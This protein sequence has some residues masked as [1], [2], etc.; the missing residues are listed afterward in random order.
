MNKLLS[1]TQL[2]SNF[3]EGIPTSE[4]YQGK[5]HLLT[6]TDNSL[7]LVNILIRKLNQALFPAYDFEKA[8]KILASD[9]IR[10]RFHN[11]RQS[12]YRDQRVLN[13]FAQVINELTEQLSW[14]FKPYV[15][16]P[17]F[18]AILP[19]MHKIPEAAD[20]FSAHRDSWFANPASQIN[21]WIPLGSYS[22]EQTFIFYPDYFSQPVKNNSSK[23]NYNEWIKLVGWQ[24]LTKPAEAIYPQVFELLPENHLGFSCNRGQRLLFSGTHLHQPLYNISDRIRFSVDI[25]LICQKDYLEQRGAPQIDNSSTGTTWNDF[26]P[27]ETWL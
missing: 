14:P 15:D 4:F 27:L 3:S 20:A 16:L 5:I 25:R 12:M 23:F 18:R 2:G 22:S 21:L 17:R 9:L 11:F 24:S 7:K 6:E 13:C 19:G 26:V 1:V 10:I 8:H